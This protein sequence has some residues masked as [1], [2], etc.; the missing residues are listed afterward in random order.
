MSSFLFW[1][2]VCSTICMKN[3]QQAPPP[4]P[5]PHPSK[6]ISPYKQP[7]RVREIV[8]TCTLLG[9]Q[10]GQ[11]NNDDIAF[12]SQ[13]SLVYDKEP[14]CNTRY[15]GDFRLEDLVS[16][17]IIRQRKKK[18]REFAVFPSHSTLCLNQAS[19][20]SSHSWRHFKRSTRE[21]RGCV[22]ANCRQNYCV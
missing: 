3:D 8:C 7:M 20:S 21:D 11:T 9:L 19:F 10:F 6:I 17:V 14:C 18:S 5:H 4:P 12:C 1:P 16:G 15:I 22:T 2:K 13:Y